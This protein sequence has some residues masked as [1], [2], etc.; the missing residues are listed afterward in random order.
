MTAKNWIRFFLAT[1][2]IATIAFVIWRERKSAKNEVIFESQKEQIKTQ[3]EI[4]ETKI[5]QQK[6]AARPDLS[7]DYDYRR[8]WLQLLTEK[9]NRS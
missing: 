2:I 6:M 8:E 4:I 7:G 5:F 1:I 9:T 3:N